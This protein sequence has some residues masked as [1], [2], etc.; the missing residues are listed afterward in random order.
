MLLAP[1]PQHPGGEGGGS[2]HGHGHGAAAAPSGGLLAS[3]L[4]IFGIGECITIHFTFAFL[5][6]VVLLLRNCLGEGFGLA[7]HGHSHGGDEGHSHGGGG[8]EDATETKV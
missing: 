4:A 1:Q 2:S 6:I 7:S 3:A 5:P 8:R